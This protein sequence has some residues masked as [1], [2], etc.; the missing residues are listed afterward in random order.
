MKT[1]YVTHVYSHQGDADCRRTDGDTDHIYDPNDPTC[2]DTVHL[3]DKA[4]DEMDTN[5]KLLNLLH[6]RSVLLTLKKSNDLDR[7]NLKIEL[8]CLILLHACLVPDFMQIY[9]ACGTTI[10]VHEV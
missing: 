1:P 8:R 10:T 2:N 9:I 5:R 4:N 3:P 6:E 7:Q